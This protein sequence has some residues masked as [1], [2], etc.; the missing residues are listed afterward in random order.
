MGAGLGRLAERPA[1]EAALLR[2]LSPLQVHGCGIQVLCLDFGCGPWSFV[3]RGYFFR[4]PKP[5]VIPSKLI[6]YAG[7]FAVESS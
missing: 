5:C 6:A 3:S 4:P 2:L 1:A 7:P